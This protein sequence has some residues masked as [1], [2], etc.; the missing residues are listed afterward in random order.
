[1]MLHGSSST[2]LGYF[3]KIYDM[4]EEEEEMQKS[5]GQGG[6]DALF[7]SLLHARLL[8]LRHLTPLGSI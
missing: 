4:L 6:D 7:S 5:R 3:L 2:D 1:M 8:T